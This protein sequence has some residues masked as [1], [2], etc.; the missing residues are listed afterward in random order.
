[1][2]ILS[3]VERS[4]SLPHG[5]FPSRETSPP[6]SAPDLEE[7][8]ARLTQQ[9]KDASVEQA[10]EIGKLVLDTLYAG[11]LVAWRSRAAKAHSLRALARR[12]DLSVSSSALYR[13]VA[14]YELAQNL[15]GLAR[16]STLGI[17]HLRL[18]LGLPMPEQRRLLDA[19]V[20]SAW[21]VAELEREAVAT[22]KR[23]PEQLGRGGR[24]RLPRFLK[25]VNRLRKAAEGAELFADVDAAAQMSPERLAEI[26]DVLATIRVRCEALDHALERAARV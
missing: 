16:W 24:P 15:G 25:S 13:A 8:A 6:E 9:G 19:A 11:D 21:T 2:H 18:V 22:R 14:L 10:L 26:R 4:S 12:D 7:L 23:G 20:R 3:I 17:S 5:S 1:M